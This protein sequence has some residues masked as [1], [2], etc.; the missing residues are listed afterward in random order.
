MP[1]SLA[2][3]TAFIEPQEPGLRCVLMIVTEDSAYIR[4]HGYVKIFQNKTVEHEAGVRL[5][6]A[7]EEFRNAQRVARIGS[8][9]W[10]A[11]M[12][13]TT[14]PLESTGHPVTLA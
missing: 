12:D 13:A 2:E 6:R 8:W 1:D 7:T 10:D 11:A 14:D 4:Q 5:E 3:L 9:V